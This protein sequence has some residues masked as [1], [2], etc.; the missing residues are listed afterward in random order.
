MKTFIV[1]GAIRDRL[2]GLAVKDVDYVVVGATPEDLIN[3]GFKP[4]GQDFPVFLHPETHEEYALARTE[5]KVAPGYKGFIFHA[6]PKVTLEEDLARRDLTINAI[7]QEISLGGELIGPMIDPFG[8]IKDVQEKVLRHIGPAF[9]ED[10]V[11]LLRVARFSARFPEFSIAPETID[12]LKKI[13]QSGELNALVKERVWQEFS[14]G[15]LANQPSKLFLTLK[16]CGV[17]ERFFPANLLKHEKI[18]HQLDAAAKNKLNLQQRCAILL[19]MLDI[20]EIKSWSDEWGIPAECKDYACLASHLFKMIS[21]HPLAPEALLEVLDR[22]DVWRKP[23]R[24]NELMIVAK[25]QGCETEVLV[26]AYLAARKVDVAGIATDLS[27]EPNA[28]QLIKE[29]IR[30]ARIATIKEL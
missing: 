9:S 2:L 30:T 22:M 7:A 11:R 8:G 12:I 15:L 3:K 17:F 6:D 24:F 23:E 26:M 13:G 29:R 10:P 28:G 20:E 1:G 14:K 16:A 21:E 4:V 19:A 27:N 18:F 25:I 5:R